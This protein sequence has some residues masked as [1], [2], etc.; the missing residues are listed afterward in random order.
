M[1]VS[2]CIPIISSFLKRIEAVGD[3]KNND[4]TVC[5]SVS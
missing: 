2:F 5:K 4:K 3:F 1:D